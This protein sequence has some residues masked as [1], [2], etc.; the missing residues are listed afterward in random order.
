MHFRVIPTKGHV[1]WGTYLPPSS[2]AGVGLLLGEKDTTSPLLG[3][4]YGSQRDPSVKEVFVLDHYM[5]MLNA[6]GILAKH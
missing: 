6:K 3:I 2:V 4:G 5:G 1:S